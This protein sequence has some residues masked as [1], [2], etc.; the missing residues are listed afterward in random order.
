MIKDGR[1]NPSKGAGITPLA[2]TAAALGM[3]GWA[4]YSYR[5]MNK[6]ILT[7]EEAE[8]HARSLLASMGIPELM[9]TWREEVLTLGDRELHLY[10]FE[11]KP[12]DPTVVHVPGTGSFALLYTE[13]QHKLSRRGFNVVGLDPRGHGA[14]SGKRGVYTLGELVDDALA[15]IEHAIATYGDKVAVS[16]DSQGGMTAFYCAAAEPRLKAAVCH[17]LIAPDEPDNTRMTR[18]PR[19][20]KVLATTRPLTQPILNT[21]LGQ[22]MQPVSAYLD[23]K[24]EETRTLP[25]IHKFFKEDPVQVNAVSFAAISSLDNTPMARRVEEIE[26]PV[27]VVHGGRDNIFP[28][29]YIRRVY[30]RLDCEKEFLY[31]PDGAHGVMLDN[32]DEIVPPIA[33]WLHKTMHD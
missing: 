23:L 10:H 12:G 31:L 33:E 5:M 21:P 32:V 1:R 6:P 20:Y 17:S 30:N 7:G 14:S 24:A 4:A 27:M 18:W 26:V 22:L 8:A 3:A 29:D 28:E 13:Y 2:L 11:S 19:Y 25:D 9:N 15:V 16:G